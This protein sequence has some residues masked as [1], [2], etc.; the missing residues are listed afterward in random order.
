MDRSLD[1][2]VASKI[3]GYTDIKEQ[4]VRGVG[5]PDHSMLFGLCPKTGKRQMVDWFS[6]GIAVAWQIVELVESMGLT[7]GV[8]FKKGTWM[9]CIGPSD[10]PFAWIWWR[11]DTVEEA[12]CRC[13]LKAKA[14]GLFKKREE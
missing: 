10:D 11:S 7:V 12:I 1:I 6:A 9:C 2:E 4:I 5:C 14:E 3:F 13:A 8:C